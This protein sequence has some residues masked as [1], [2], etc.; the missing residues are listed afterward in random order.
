[1]NK[2]LNTITCSKLQK[3]FGSKECETNS[4]SGIKK[5]R[6]Q[7]ECKSQYNNCTRFF[8]RIVEF[9]LKILIH[10]ERKCPIICYRKEIPE[11]LIYF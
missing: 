3:I 7:R 4:L 2:V 5:E 9:V 8:N 11:Y 10:Y 6:V 1:M